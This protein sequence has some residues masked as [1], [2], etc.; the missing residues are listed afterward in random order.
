MRFYEH[1]LTILGEECDEV[2]QRVSKALRFGLS[3]VQPGQEK[4]NADRI[5]DELHDITV[6]RDMLDDYGILKVPHMNK[7]DYDRRYNKVL[8]FIEFARKCGTIEETLA[9]APL[10][11]PPSPP[12]DKRPFNCRNRLRDN[13]KAYPKSGCRVCTDFL[14]RGCPYERQSTDE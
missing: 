7:V 13:G 9:E 4:T 1:L 11:T 2:G 10:E 6:I 14:I 12:V 8:Q 3:E 5:I